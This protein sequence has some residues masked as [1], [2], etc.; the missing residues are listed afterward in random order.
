MAQKR[1]SKKTI[2]KT[3][4]R[5]KKG[6]VYIA[7]YKIIILCAAI[8]AVCMALLLI[9]TIVTQNSYEEPVNITQRFTDEKKVSEKSENKTKSVKQTKSEKQEK[10]T[11]TKITPKNTSKDVSKT[12]NKIESK[13]EAKTKNDVK[14]KAETKIE[15]K[16]KVETKPKIETKTENKSEPKTEIKKQPEVI[17][18]PVTP[19]TQPSSSPANTPAVTKPDSVQNNSA[20]TS[21]SAQKQT[22][23]KYNF[24][25]A[26][27]GAQL[28]FLFDDGGQ[29]L[30]HLEKFLSLPFPI[31]IAVLP[32]LAHS[33]ESAERIRKSG[34]ELMLHQ[35]MQ[36]VNAN[37]NPGPGA[38]TPD[39]TESQIQATLFQNINEIG[40]IAG[41]NNHEGSRITAD[42]EKM[43][44]I[45]KAASREG[46]YF[47]DS[48]TNSD[49]KV[50][51]VATEL[52]LSYYE[53]NGRF[54]DNEK[55]KENALSEIRKNLDIA[56][57]DGVVIMIGHIWSADF[58]PAVLQEI[59]PEL[60]EKGY[61]FKTVSA[62]RGLKK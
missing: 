32:R 31:T 60:I 29:N 2:R 51:Y 38:I 26:R 5:T 48:R 62:C 36:A 40:P 58:L 55:T 20:V 45:L 44:V 11:E 21:S 46:V 13:P 14:I 15:N 43:E 28:V 27:N 42:A 41:L 33:K 22:A 49:T 37:V 23:N 12:E 16:P 6:K 10:K 9:T 56:N 1:K 7:P 17:R 4:K 25:A 34:K 24:P 61:T 57:K 39:M 3:K 52:G 50:P 47:L 35:P 18:T 30:S 53:R 54:L 8:I 59:Y 19:V